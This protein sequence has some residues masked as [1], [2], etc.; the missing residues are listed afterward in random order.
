MMRERR[1]NEGYDALR[2]SDVASFRGPIYQSARFSRESWLQKYRINEIYKISKG[3]L[4]PRALYVFVFPGFKRHSRTLFLSALL[5]ARTCP[6]TGLKA[7]GRWV[8]FN[9]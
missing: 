2:T 6:S 1:I 3:V 8:D 7:A 4:P 5:V 9:V